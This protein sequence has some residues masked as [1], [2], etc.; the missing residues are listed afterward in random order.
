MGLGQQLAQKVEGLCARDAHGPA[1]ALVALYGVQKVAGQEVFLQRGMGET[2]GA[3]TFVVLPGEE[4]GGAQVLVQFVLVRFRQRRGV[5]VAQVFVAPDPAPEDGLHVLGRRGGFLLPP[6]PGG[7][8]CHECALVI[9]VDEVFSLVACQPALHHRFVE[10]R[11]EHRLSAGAVAFDLR[12][13]LGNELEGEGAGGQL[14]QVVDA[15]H[16]LHDARD[17]AA[18]Q[19]GFQV[20]TDL[21]IAQGQQGH[22]PVG[23]G[24]QVLPLLA[25]KEGTL[26]QQ[27]PE[28][29]GA[30]GQHQPDSPIRIL[31]VEQLQRAEQ[32]VEEQ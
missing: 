29:L 30:A 3:A 14:R 13:V 9:R 24:P 2:E 7:Q 15:G 27:G 8:L 18:G 4:G 31:V 25:Q 19:R 32:P 22:G 17:I 28:I 23:I 5:D 1:G 12:N 10:C 21:F 16:Q 6:Q 26:I 20:A 11:P